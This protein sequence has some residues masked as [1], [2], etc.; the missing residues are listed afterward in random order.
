MK[1]P[2]ILK[3]ELSLLRADKSAVITE[4]RAKSKEIKDV[5]NEISKLESKQ[6]EVRS[7]IQEETA[8]LDDIRNR[9]VS[10]RNEL[11]VNTQEL[12][13]ILNV[14]D[15]SKTKNAQEIKLY[16]G[17]IKEL[18]EK[19]NETILEIARLKSLFDRNSRV[20]NQN[21][22]ERL[23]KVRSL[24]SDIKEKTSE[25]AKL[26]TELA[27]KEAT[28]KKLTK[29][30]LKREDKIRL[31]EKNLDNKE[32]SLNKWEEDLIAMSKDMTIVYG[33]LKELY[34]K[35]DPAIDLDK[36]IIKAL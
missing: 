20:Y 10:V 33:R 8:R 31:R 17:R 12:K 21:E 29:D 22:S 2:T 36:L 24:D 18:E 9:A 30:R 5:S 14:L 7:E 26:T 15:I 3:D 34:V 16:L 35:V 13:N 4:L 11:A 27:K 25:L 6:E 32:L 28:E 23:S 1:N 19:E